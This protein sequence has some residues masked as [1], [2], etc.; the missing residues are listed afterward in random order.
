MWLF[1]MLF[2]I[3]HPHD[4]KKDAEEK[5][6]HDF[7]AL[8]LTTKSSYVYFEWGRR[9]KNNNNMWVGVFVLYMCLHVIAMI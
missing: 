9:K 2:C 3:D 5:K 7:L 4:A 6:E 1:D 8:A